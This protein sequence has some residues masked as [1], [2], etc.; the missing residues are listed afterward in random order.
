MSLLVILWGLL[1]V[2]L[3][4]VGI[5]NPE[6]LLRFAGYWDNPAGLYGAAFLRVFVGLAIFLAA[7]DSRAPTVFRVLGPVIVV[8]GLSTPFWGCERTHRIL[9]WWAGRS[10]TFKRL[11]AGCAMFFGL[12][13]I[14]LA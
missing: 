2:V 7:P 9:E 12:I 14:Y 1:M 11:W 6:R 5:V 4:V 8:A 13:L 10:D 3:G